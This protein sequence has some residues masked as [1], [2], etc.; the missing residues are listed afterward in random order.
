MKR[1]TKL[2]IETLKLNYCGVSARIL[3]KELR[4]SI[5][6]VIHK[7]KKLGLKSSLRGKGNAQDNKGSNNPNW[8]SSKGTEGQ[9][10]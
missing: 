8:K 3:S 2:E 6:A 10:I 9:S 1:W 5:R 7:A 4:R